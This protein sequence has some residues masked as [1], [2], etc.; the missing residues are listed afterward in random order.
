MQALERSMKI[1]EILSDAEQGGMSISELSG[2][3]GL[4]LSTMHRILQGMAR[5]R[6]VEQ[7]EHSK[8]YRLGP[9]WM[10]YGLRLY[11]S[12]DY[13]TK[14]RPELE[15]LAREVKESVYLSR[16]SGNEAI[17][18]ERIDSEENPIRINDPLGIRIPL[19][20]GAAN[21]AILAAMPA[22]RAR[23]IVE[24]LVPE[25]K[26]DEFYIMLQQIRETGFA[27]SHGERTP[28]TASVAVAVKD[29]LGEVIG[30]VSIGFLDYELEEERL[31]YLSEKVKEAGDRIGRKLGA[32]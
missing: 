4:A 13:V 9:V 11:D 19:H 24:N 32:G 10:E 3:S 28:G 1:A 20:I 26:R 8:L 21:K 25:E 16:P 22:D 12:M 29:G 15:Q 30:A 17:V 27:E 18:M 14:I 5:Q 23:R 31:A 6:M 2:R 7:D